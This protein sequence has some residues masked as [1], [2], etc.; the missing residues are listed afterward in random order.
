MQCK[1][2][3]HALNAMYAEYTVSIYETYVELAHTQPLYLPNDSLHCKVP[4]GMR[5]CEDADFVLQHG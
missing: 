5:L 3:P 1:Y 2:V 4:L